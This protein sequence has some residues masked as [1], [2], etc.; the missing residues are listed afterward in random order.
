MINRNLS[1]S[2]INPN[3]GP[4][5]LKKCGSH[6]H[7]FR[8]HFSSMAISDFFNPPSASH[9]RKSR[10]RTWDERCNQRKPCL[11]YR[12]KTCYPSGLAKLQVL[13]WSCSNFAERPAC[14]ECKFYTLLCSQSGNVLYIIQ[15][16]Q[17]V[18]HAFNM[19]SVSKWLLFS[20][21]NLLVTPSMQLLWLY[22]LL[23]FPRDQQPA[24]LPCLRWI[25]VIINSCERQD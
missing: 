2:N 5:I 14:W 19:F 16:V 25:H 18:Q 3:F 7:T 13:H 24:E 23:V 10:L 17:H 15:N 20:L 4:K 11:I 21:Y 22:N 8:V 12:N 6:L 1:V 9:L